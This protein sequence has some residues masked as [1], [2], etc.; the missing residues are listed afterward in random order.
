MAETTDEAA[1]PGVHE[2]RRDQYLISTDKRRLD[3]AVIH[4]FLTTS[5][6]SAGIPLETVQRAI[7]HSLAFGVYDNEQ[8]VGMARVIS[9]YTTFAYVADVFILDTYR[10]QGLGLWLMECVIAHPHLQGLR[11]WTLFT[12]DAHGLYEKVGFK[13]SEVPDRLMER[14]FPNIYNV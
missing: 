8:Q 12:R 11:R 6:W 14:A 4:G 10:G 1:F 9:D 13:R 7:E 3:L 2:W 5:Y